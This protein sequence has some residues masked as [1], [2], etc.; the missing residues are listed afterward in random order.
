M[1]IEQSVPD[2]VRRVADSAGRPVGTGR[3]GIVELRTRPGRTKYP[4]A[5]PIRITAVGME[6]FS[7]RISPG[8]VREISEDQFSVDAAEAATGLIRDFQRQVEELKKRYYE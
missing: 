8:T 5:P 3:G 1:R 6:N 4:L 7:V 2:H